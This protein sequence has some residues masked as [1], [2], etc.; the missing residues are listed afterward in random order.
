[1]RYINATSISLLSLYDLEVDETVE[2]A[3][4]GCKKFTDLVAVK[5]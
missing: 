3:D 1:M 5:T 4:T 2:V